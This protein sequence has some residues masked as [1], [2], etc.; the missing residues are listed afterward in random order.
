[1]KIILIFIVLILS[2]STGHAQV[3]D[4]TRR[5]VITLR[6]AV[7]TA[8]TNNN[9]LDIL[10]RNIQIQRL[11]I[12]AAK[13]DLFPRL[14]LNGSW[15]RN[16]TVSK[17]G[18]IFQNGVPIPVSSQNTTRDNFNL[19]LNSNITLFDGFANYETV[20]A[21]EQ[22]ELLLRVDRQKNEFDVVNNVVNAYF[23]VL[24]KEKLV[25][26]NRLNLENSIAQLER[27]RE[28]VAVGRGTTL[29]ILK[30]DVLVAQDEL[31]LEQ[32][33]N[34]FDKSKVDLLFQMTA[35]VDREIEV[36]DSGVESEVETEELDLV[37]SAYRNTNVLFQR[38]VDNRYDYRYIEQDIRLNEIRHNIAEKQFY[39]PIVSAF[40]N[41]NLSGENV[42]EIHDQRVLTFGLQFSYPIFQGFQFDNRRQITQINIQQGRIELD[43]LET[44]IKADLKKAVLD[45]ETL[46]KRI[47]ILNRNIIAAEQDVLLSEE[48][49]RL[50]LGTLLEVQ[51]AQTRLNNFRIERINAIYDFYIAKNRI[52][53][54]T[55]ELK[56]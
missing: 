47:D 50:G 13:G 49:Y 5:E 7:N 43:Q 34:D 1:M 30:Q 54:I 19:G 41:Y 16:N 45:L 14:T 46:N 17:G 23:E 12:R 52:D 42:S 36:S 55:G 26:I 3:D 33:I 18:V 35:D 56:L 32:S 29:D 37:L 31:N 15:T 53:Y 22:N 8:I 10:D 44:Q 25:E 24:K 4:P 21:E 38:A 51:T 9:R 28:F 6:E 48:S 2:V 39:F 20:T 11:S 40:G 27:I